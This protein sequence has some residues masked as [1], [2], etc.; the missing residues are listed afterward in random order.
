MCL[1]CAVPVQKAQAV[2]SLFSEPFSGSARGR[3]SR[4]VPSRLTE[5]IP[6]AGVL[7]L[8]A[9]Q[10]IEM[11]HAGAVA[12]TAFAWDAPPP[13]RGAGGVG[14][15]LGLFW[16]P[17]P[18][19]HP[20]LVQLAARLSAPRSLGCNSHTTRLGLRKRIE[21]SARSVY[22]SRHVGLA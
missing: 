5:R 6:V 12:V 19:G 13:P 4:D 20:R 7:G 10:A 2:S 1:Q 3:E 16:V 15:I 21:C 14:R 8:L 18:G 9:A 11:C 22:D 17:F